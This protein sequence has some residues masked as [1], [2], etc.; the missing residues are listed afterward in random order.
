MD[1]KTCK[2]CQSILEICVDEG[3]ECTSCQN[4]IH[5]KCLKRGSVPGGL[6]GDVFYSLVCQ[7]CAI[8][9]KESFVRNKISW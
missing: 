1:N 4:S 3:I 9:D 6:N 8:D 7:E 2:Y 5:V